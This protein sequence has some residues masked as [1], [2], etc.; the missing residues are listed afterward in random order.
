MD[1]NESRSLPL[2]RQS[3]LRDVVEGGNAMPRLPGWGAEMHLGRGG[4]YTRRHF[5][6]CLDKP[7][8]LSIED[9]STLI[10]ECWQK[11]WFGY[12]EIVVK[13]CDSGW[14]SYMAKF[15]TKDDYSDSIDW[16]NFNNS[17]CC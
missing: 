14:L 16:L 1:R 3:T 7:E 15:R 2:W 10:N 12:D 11:T 6:L 9:F 5:H 13:E 8:S 17:E 4:A